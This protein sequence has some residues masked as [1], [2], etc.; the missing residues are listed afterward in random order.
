MHFR[1]QV[2]CAQHGQFA[3]LEKTLS[4]K[5]LTLPGLPTPDEPACLELETGL[6]SPST[7]EV[8]FPAP[9]SSVPTGHA[10]GSWKSLHSPAKQKKKKHMRNNTRKI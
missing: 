3:Q 9:L 1:H 5:L 10:F 6:P 2:G 8:D 7:T 4:R